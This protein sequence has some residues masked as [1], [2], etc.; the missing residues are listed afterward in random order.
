MNREVETVEQSLATLSV[1]EC[2]LIIDSL[3]LYGR[4]Y[5]QRR[6]EL[7][8]RAIQFYSSGQCRLC[9]G[10]RDRE[11][12]LH[13]CWDEGSQADPGPGPGDEA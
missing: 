6:A 9:G 11:W 13:R 2:G 7:L 1:H 8:A 4:S 5:G 3:R 12:P 10:A